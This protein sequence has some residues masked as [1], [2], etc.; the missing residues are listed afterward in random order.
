MGVLP[1]KIR[2]VREVIKEK[3]PNGVDVVKKTVEYFVF[4]DSKL[5]A[6][7][8]NLEGVKVSTDSV[9]HVMSGLYD[10]GKSVTIS[11]LHKAIK[12]VNQ[13][14]N[15]INIVLCLSNAYIKIKNITITNREICPYLIAI[16]FNE[17]PEN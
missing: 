2:K 4:N 15:F 8:Q 10:H 13:L 11:H 6:L 7:S 17:S 3:A 9:A 5:Q 1:T 12:P 16:S 14:T